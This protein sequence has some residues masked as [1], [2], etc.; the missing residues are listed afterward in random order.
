MMR[1]I[2]FSL[3]AFP[4]ISLACTSNTTPCIDD[5]SIL[6]SPQ[7][8]LAWEDN[9]SGGSIVGNGNWRHETMQTGEHKTN[10]VYP[11]KDGR[12]WS[13]WYDDHLGTTS[14]IDTWTYPED[15]LIQ[16]GIVGYSVAD[17]ERD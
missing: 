13:A 3:L 11:T 5:P 16:R 14:Y 1:F 10:N 9:F 2:L 12:R 15:A 4:T 7:F 17:P 8:S 6:G